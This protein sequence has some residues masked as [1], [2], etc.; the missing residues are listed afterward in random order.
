MTSERDEIDTLVTHT[1][2]RLAANC[3]IWLTILGT[4]LTRF[5]V[6]D[7]HSTIMGVCL[8]L[9]ILAIVYLVSRRNTFLPFLGESVVPASLVQDPTYPP[10][11]D[12]EVDVSAAPGASHVAY[13]AADQSI[14]H[15]DTGV[16][17]SFPTPETA[18]GSYGNS[19]IA[20]VKDDGTATLRIK[21]PGRYAVRGKLLPKHVHYR[22]VFQSG[23]MGPVK[24]ANVICS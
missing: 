12:I 3:V 17:K 6:L 18:Y 14:K 5:N 22:D 1:W 11:A 13:W 16:A 4:I 9:S 24:K 15:P 20:K 19:G 2:V 7:I 23:I 10:T 8:G 21:C